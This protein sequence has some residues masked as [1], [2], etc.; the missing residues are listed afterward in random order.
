MTQTIDLVECPILVRLKLG[1]HFMLRHK[2]ALQLSQLFFA[3]RDPLLLLPVSLCCNLETKLGVFELLLQL[4]VL[5][6]L[7]LLQGFDSAMHSCLEL[8]IVGFCHILHTPGFGHPLVLCP[9]PPVLIAVTAAPFGRH[10]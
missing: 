3:I 1:V 7:L 9:C 8:T 10:S 5:L 6:L 4:G 2:Q